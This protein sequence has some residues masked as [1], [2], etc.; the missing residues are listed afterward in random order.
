MKNE[1]FENEML[2]VAALKIDSHEAFVKIFLHYYSDL[3]IFA[4]RFI[5]DKETCEDIV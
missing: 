5:P 3:A 4:S 1:K 2:L